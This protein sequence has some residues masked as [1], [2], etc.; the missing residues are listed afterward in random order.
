M[1]GTTCAFITRCGVI[2]NNFLVT[3]QH[4][5]KVQEEKRLL[6]L[7]ASQLSTTMPGVRYVFVRRASMFM[8]NQAGE[9]QFAPG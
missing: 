4:A 6:Q 7:E 9:L 3:A 8:S 1:T 5:A 2:G